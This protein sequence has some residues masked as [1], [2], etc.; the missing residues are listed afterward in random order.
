M[1]LTFCKATIVII[2][3]SETTK[4]LDRERIGSTFSRFFTYIVY[5]ILAFEIVTLVLINSFFPTGAFL[6]ALGDD[7]QPIGI[8][9]EKKEI[10]IPSC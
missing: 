3:R 10:I 6:F 9:I 1:N 5:L 4:L 7:Y 2:M 8:F